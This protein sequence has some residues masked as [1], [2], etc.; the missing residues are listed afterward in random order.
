MDEIKIQSNDEIEEE[1]WEGKSL[2]D[3]HHQGDSHEGVNSR[4]VDH[5][6]IDYESFDYI[7]VTKFPQQVVDLRQYPRAGFWKRFYAL[8]VDVAINGIITKLFMTLIASLMPVSELWIIIISTL[9]AVLIYFFYFL[10]PLRYWGRTIGKKIFSLQI[11]NINFTTNLTYKQI[12]LREVVGKLV[13][14]LTLLIGYLMA[15]FRDKRALHDL[16]AETL[17]IQGVKGKSIRIT[18]IDQEID[19]SDSLL[20]KIPEKGIEPTQTKQADLTPKGTNLKSAL[21][22]I[23]I[24]GLGL[25][26]VYLGMDVYNQ[27]YGTDVVQQ[28][29]PSKRKSRRVVRRR[30]K[31]LAARAIPKHEP[32][33]PVI[34]K[35][36]KQKIALDKSVKTGKSVKT[37]RSSKKKEMSI[38]KLEKSLKLDPK[39]LKKKKLFQVGLK[40]IQRRDYPKAIAY[41]NA[42]YPISDS[43]SCVARIKYAQAF[44][45]YGQQK[46]CRSLLKSVMKAGT[47]CQ[48]SYRKV[49]KNLWER[50]YYFDAGWPE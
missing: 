34:D 41:I 9:V 22:F 39:L 44:Y 4:G 33:P 7:S 26:I 48:E 18:D 29:P 11:I 6:N 40:I 35:S 15:M 3:D 23:L 14:D 45:R 50:T 47:I 43:S 19:V 37:D 36:G 8:V 31:A 32:P 46:L 5:E 13:S 49:A 2:N 24:I 21:A 42:V 10:F 20:K 38:S 25:G 16:I 1:F 12:F 30:R 28:T 17:V 27:Y